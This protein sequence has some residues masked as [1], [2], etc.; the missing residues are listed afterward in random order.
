MIAIGPAGTFQAPKPER[1][2]PWL[3]QVR[4]PYCKAGVGEGCRINRRTVCIAVLGVHK[5]RQRAA[6]L[7]GGR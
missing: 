1:K 4:C 3:L 6:Q 7:R 5:P 2:I